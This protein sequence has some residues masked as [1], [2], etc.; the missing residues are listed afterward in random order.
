MTTL[1][2]TQT[3]QRIGRIAAVGAVALLLAGA[4]MTPAEA[5]RRRESVKLVNDAMGACMDLG[6]DPAAEEATGMLNPEGSEGSLGGGFSFSCL[7]P[8]GSNIWTWIPYTND[9]SQADKR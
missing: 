1:M 7:M 9:E 2:R 4:V 3:T 6:G 5:M 8:D